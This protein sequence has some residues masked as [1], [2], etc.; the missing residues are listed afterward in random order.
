MQRER[1]HQKALFSSFNAEF[2][3]TRY[4]GSKVKLVDWIWR[5]IEPFEFTSCLDAFGGTGCVAYRLKRE[6]KR[7]TYNDHL[8][9]NHLIG[10]ALIVNG[11]V[12]L[13]PEEVDWLMQRHSTISYP[14]FVQETFPEIYFTDEENGW[15]DQTITNIRQ[16]DDPYKSALAF[17]ALSQACLVK[18]PYNLF[19]RKNLYLRLARVE[20]SFGNKTTWEKPFE[21]WFRH[22]AEEGNRAV[23]DNGARN[24]ALN[25]DALDVPGAYDLVYLDPPYISR[26]RGGLDYLGFYHFLEGLTIYDAWGAHIDY[27]S[28]HR[29]LRRR[30]SAW[31]DP[32]AI[33]AAF[34]EIFRRY[35]ESILVVSYRSDGIP[36]VSEL[37]SLLKRYKERVAVERSGRYRYVLSTGSNSEEILLIGT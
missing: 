11:D 26:R 7:V 31:T 10:R 27:G 1:F 2:P 15:I 16:L 12:R 34:D 29:R 36:S 14:R 35:R 13:A 17:F 22:F 24:A 25:H 30:W 5:A 9:F 19:H 20:R 6:G 28:K 3:S 37:I 32:G 23:F 18:R 33:H 4:Q 8:R 21:A